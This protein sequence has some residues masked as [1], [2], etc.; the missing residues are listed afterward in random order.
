MSEEFRII[1]KSLPRFDGPVKV[2]GEVKFLEDI[3]IPGCW[4]GGVIRSDVPRGVVRKIE[5]LPAFA[6]T[7]AVLVTAEDIP[8]ENYVAIVRSDYP[9]LAAPAVNYATQAVALVAAPDAESITVS[10]I[11]TPS[12]AICGRVS[13]RPTWWWRE[14]GRRGCRSRCT[15]RRRAWRPGAQATASSFSVRCSVPST[16]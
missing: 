13:R 6:E 10:T 15:L 3:E 1:G 4:L 7:G 16:W 8:G 12:A 11:I 14:N 5:T 2:A 9:A